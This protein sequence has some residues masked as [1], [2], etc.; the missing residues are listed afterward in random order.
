MADCTGVFFLTRGDPVPTSWPVCRKL[1]HFEAFYKGA[2][3][4]YCFS[5]LIQKQIKIRET[6]IKQLKTT[7]PKKP[8]K[9]T[10]KKQK[11]HEKQ[12]LKKR[13]NKKQN[14]KN[15]YPYVSLELSV[16]SCFFVELAGFERFWGGFE[17]WFFFICFIY[18]FF[19][20][21]FLDSG[22]V[23]FWFVFCD[24]LICVLH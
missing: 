14:A 8:K 11:T 4:R 1:R 24:C 10:N 18:I 5:T 15:M 2:G 7:P 20:I 9:K 17:K 6:K 23:L 3:G 21:C 13:L 16:S 22:F 12:R 19:L